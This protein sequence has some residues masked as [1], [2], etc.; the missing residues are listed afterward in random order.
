MMPRLNKGGLLAAENFGYE[1]AAATTL[2]EHIRAAR[3]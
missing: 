1:A 3:L 2:P